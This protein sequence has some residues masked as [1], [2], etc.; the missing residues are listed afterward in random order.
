M[1]ELELTTAEQLKNYIEAIEEQE[2]IKQDI[3]DKIKEI[4]ASAE[5]TGFN[6]KIIKLIIKQ[7]KKR[8]E[9]IEEEESLLECYRIA[10]DRVNS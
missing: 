8:K 10:L 6:A 5:N 3:A 4:Y 2:T 7:R 1:T 9:E